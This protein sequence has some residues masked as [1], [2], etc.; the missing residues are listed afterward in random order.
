M[1]VKKA[2][3]QIAVSSGGV[4]QKRID[5]HHPAQVMVPVVA[6][7]AALVVLVEWV[8][9]ARKRPVHSLVVE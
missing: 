4:R 5:H 9:V 6:A 2:L 8:P 7:P 1:A 3:E